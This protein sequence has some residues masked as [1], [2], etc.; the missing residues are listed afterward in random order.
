MARSCADPLGG[1]AV[2]K[3]YLEI[4]D[5]VLARFSELGPVGRDIGE[6][7]AGGD[8]GVYSET[9]LKGWD[10]ALRIL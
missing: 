6:A 8:P 2:E 9:L 7:L 10:R 4:I 1:S 5:G 3:I